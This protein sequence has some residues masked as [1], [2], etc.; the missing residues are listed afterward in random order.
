M[1]V[2]R[3]FGHISPTGSTLGTRVRRGGYLEDARRWLL[4]ETLARGEGDV[5]SYV[6]FTA[7]MGSPAHSEIIRDGRYRQVG[8]GLER[9]TSADDG[10]L[11][12]TL[13]FGVIIAR[14]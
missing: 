11:T 9:G 1:V 10:G 7:L 8:V 5:T 3:F 6:L 4:G 12:V 2:N 13:D 14:R